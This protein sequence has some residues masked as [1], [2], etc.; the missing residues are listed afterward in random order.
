MGKI[1]TNNSVLVGTAELVNYV[2]FC[3]CAFLT[4]GVFHTVGP[5]LL[6]CLA[7][8]AFAAGVTLVYFSKSAGWM[9]VVGA[10]AHGGGAGIVWTCQ[11]AL[12]N[13]YA[14]ALERAVYLR[15][16]WL[17]FNTS[18][19]MCGIITMVVPRDG[20]VSHLTFC[21]LLGVMLVSACLST[22]LISDPNAVVRTDGSPVLFLKPASLKYDFSLLI[23][24]AGDSV[25]FKMMPLILTSAWAD[26]YEF[27]RLVPSLFN[28]EAQGL[29][30]A[31]YSVAQMIGVQLLVAVVGSRRLEAHRRDKAGFLLHCILCLIAFG[32]TLLLQYLFTCESGWEKGDGH[33]APARGSAG[34]K[35]CPPGYKWV[36][37][38]NLGSG[39]LEYLSILATVVL[40][41]MQ[42]AVQHCWGLWILSTHAGGS[43]AA[44]VR[45]AAYFRSIECAGAGISWALD[46]T[47]LSSGAQLIICTVLVGLA[48]ARAC[49][50]ADEQPSQANAKSVRSQTEHTMAS[51]RVYGPLSEESDNDSLDS[52]WPSSTDDLP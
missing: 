10:V 42:N 33:C 52:A 5:Q 50:A 12:I 46:R 27:R 30:I 4:G 47:A 41:G 16:F 45:Y 21:L 35:I 48:T 8:T 29:T 15:D 37:G 14:S 1:G 38:C 40:M 34:S 3:V 18:G 44:N 43:V 22:C 51:V 36:A 25:M 28:R 23:S 9:R 24:A 26:T 31:L 20:H 19:V 6:M 49:V 2:V 7:G 39:D 11:T 13:S 17:V 32:S